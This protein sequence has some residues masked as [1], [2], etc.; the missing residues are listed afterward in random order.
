VENYN[1]IPFT[2]NQ[3]LDLLKSRGLIINNPDAELK[4]LRQ[5]NYYRFTAYC[6]PFQHPH[7]VFLPGTTFETIEGLYRLDEELRLHILGMLSPI[8][9]YLRTQMAYELSHGWGTFAHYEPSM[10]QNEDDHQ[11]WLA[12]LEDDINNAHEIF[13]EHYK[14]KYNGFPKLPLWM[15]CEVM[16]IGRLSKFYSCLTPTAQRKICSIVGVDH[17]VLKSWLHVITYIR[18]ICAH[19]GRLWNRMF[20]IQ[21]RLL[22]KNP[23]WNAITFNNKRLFATVAMAEWICRKA[24]LP[25]CN[26]EPVYETMRKIAALDA[27]F[28]VMMGVPPGKAIGLC[29]ENL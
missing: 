19:H 20:T 11:A 17:N 16:S 9:I 26:V 1:K 27:R 29:W 18:N 25:M 10:F 15:A 22:D 12:D 13:L 5:V 14:T 23:Q 3:H 8:E 4:F 2:Y 28:A 24:E 21:P 7:D 6:I